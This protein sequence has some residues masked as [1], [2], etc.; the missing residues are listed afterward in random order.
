MTWGPDDK[1]RTALHEA[2]HAVVAWSFGVTVGCI[3]LDLENTSGQ[4]LRRLRTSRR[5]SKL[6]NALPGSRRSRPSNLRPIKAG[7]AMTVI[8]TCRQYFERTGPPTMNPGDKNC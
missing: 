2:G 4:W 7:R 6:P 1:D 5:S 3:H 8:T